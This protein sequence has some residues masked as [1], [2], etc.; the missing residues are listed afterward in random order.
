[1]AADRLGIRAVGYSWAHTLEGGGVLG[2]AGRV[3]DPGGAGVRR[4]RR[5]RP[6]GRA[7][8]GGGRRGCLCR[9]HGAASSSSPSPLLGFVTVWRKR[10]PFLS[11]FLDRLGA[12]HSGPCVRTGHCLSTV[13]Q[14]LSLPHTECCDMGQKALSSC[15]QSNPSN[16]LIDGSKLCYGH[17]LNFPRRETLALC[18][19]NMYPTTN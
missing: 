15:I 10:A 6:R 9:R 14:Q 5:R 11:L 7:V 16:P 3:R 4:L 2:E 12:D 17:P 18:T 1:M 8:V 19:N 13:G